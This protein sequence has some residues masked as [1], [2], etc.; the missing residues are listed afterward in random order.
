M[1]EYKNNKKR[2]YENDN[3]EW[4]PDAHRIDDNHRI[5]DDDSMNQDERHATESTTDEQWGQQEAAWWWA[6]DW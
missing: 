5:D 6:T 2:S 3:W 4:T 1:P